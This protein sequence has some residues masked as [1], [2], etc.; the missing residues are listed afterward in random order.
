MRRKGGEKE[1][2]RVREIK[3]KRS[4]KK[5]REEGKSAFGVKSNW[6]IFSILY[7]L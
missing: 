7:D 3:Q 6:F 1:G 5:G 2:R 4:G